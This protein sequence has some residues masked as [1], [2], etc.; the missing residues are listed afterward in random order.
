MTTNER[1]S[2]IFTTVITRAYFVG[3]PLLRGHP[4]ANK[5]HAYQGGVYGQNYQVMKDMI[6]ILWCP[7]FNLQPN[8]WFI[9]GKKSTE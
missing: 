2:I 1:Q 5:L 3:N 8:C 9:N 6:G 4:L 7:I